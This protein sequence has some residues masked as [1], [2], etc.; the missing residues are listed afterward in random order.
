MSVIHNLHFK[1]CKVR[2]VRL[3]K[4]EI[5]KYTGKT[6][7]EAEEI[8]DSTTDHKPIIF[9]RRDIQ[10]ASTMDIQTNEETEDT[11]E[12]EYD[13]INENEET[14]DTLDGEYGGIN[15]NEETEDTVEEEYDSI[16]ENEET[17]DT[18]DGEYGGINENEETE[19]TV[20]EE[21]DGINE[22]QVADNMYAAGSNVLIDDLIFQQYD[23]DTN[24]E[25]EDTSDMENNVE[26]NA[27][28]QVADNNMYV[29][30]NNF[31]PNMNVQQYDMDTTEGN[32]NSTNGYIPNLIIKQEVQDDGYNIYTSQVAGSS[33][34]IKQ[35]ITDDSYNQSYVTQGNDNM[36]DE[37]IPN[38]LVNEP[39]QNFGMQ[40]YINPET[41]NITNGSNSHVIIKQEI[42]DE[43]NIE[44]YTAVL[45]P[46]ADQ[47][48]EDGGPW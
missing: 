17:E 37:Y 5:E 18:L 44:T 29:E 40:S 14:E 38:I 36:Y 45:R 27:S 10:N 43:G 48:Y 33:L 41:S 12:E 34:M 4:E 25:T 30:P 21:Y 26:M 3:T 47:E 8:A 20:E 16:N 9:V 15:E 7:N 46:S 6:Y 23:M 42:L 13:S 11:V 31:R 35:E 39:T 22:T 19:D 32:D 1:E 2:L 24:E 28:S